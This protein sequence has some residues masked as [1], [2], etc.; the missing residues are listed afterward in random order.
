MTIGELGIKG[1]DD[2][3]TG[4]CPGEQRRVFIPY[5]LAY[6]ADGVE[7]F[8]DPESNLILEVAFEQKRDRVLNFLDR[9]SSG[10][11]DFG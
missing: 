4:A 8:V 1:W 2:A 3:L 5:E 9:I 10:R 11:L 7:D 6:G